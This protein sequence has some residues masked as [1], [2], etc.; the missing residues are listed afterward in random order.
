LELLKVTVS[1]VGGT[2]AV[3]TCIRCLGRGGRAGALDDGGARVKEGGRFGVV[4]NRR[5]IVTK[6]LAEGLVGMSR[7]NGRI[8]RLSVLR[9][10]QV[11]ITGCQGEIYCKWWLLDELALFAGVGAIPNPVSHL[12]RWRPVLAGSPQSHW[13]V[14]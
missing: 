6:R 4:A 8:A 1:N 12:H 2:T 9:W 10:S 11:K 13:S 5:G 14:L 7:T 3:P